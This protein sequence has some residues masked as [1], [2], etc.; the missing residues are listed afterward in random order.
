MNQDCLFCPILSN[1]VDLSN[2]TR[3]CHKWAIKSCF[4]GD[5]VEMAKKCYPLLIV[6]TS[7]VILSHHE[8]KSVLEPSR[9]QT[10]GICHKWAITL[11]FYGLLAEM[12]KKCYKFLNVLIRPVILSHQKVKSVHEPGFKWAH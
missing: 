5:L 4:D 3:I 6:L 12:A 8:T 2:F 10:I 9:T 11:C 7:L 1:I